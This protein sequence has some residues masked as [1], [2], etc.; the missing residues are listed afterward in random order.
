MPP[1]KGQAPVA[2]KKRVPRVGSAAVVADTTDPM[3]ATLQH[4]WQASQEVHPAAVV[5]ADASAASASS[6]ADMPQPSSAA[7]GKANEL[8]APE[9]DVEG[10]L[11]PSEHLPFV[12]EAGP[13][14]TEQAE[15]G[16]GVGS[17]LTALQSDDAGKTGISD[18]ADVHFGFDHGE[19]CV[20][21]DWKLVENDSIDNLPDS[22]SD[23]P[24]P[25]L[26]ECE[27]EAESL[28]KLT[29]SM[30]KDFIRKY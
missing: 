8:L 27:S 12:V 21:E 15:E 22:I 7:R 28:D 23:V 10:L 18:M 2:S 30:E 16:F 14:V 11:P 9:V 19:A 6:S 5:P 17:L 20:Q 4:V 3:Q 25:A 26:C 1:R 29:L 24:S 13:A